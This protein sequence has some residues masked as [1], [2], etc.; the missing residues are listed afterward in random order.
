M[1]TL[2][3]NVAAVIGQAPVVAQLL[4]LFTVV[5]GESPPLGDVDLKKERKLLL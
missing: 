5:L 1:L 3:L 4:V 2:V